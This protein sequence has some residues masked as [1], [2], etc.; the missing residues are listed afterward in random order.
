MKSLTA[1]CD[2]RVE[3]ITDC[4]RTK[5]DVPPGKTKASKRGFTLI[6]LLVV[7]AIIGILAAMLLPALNSARDKG[8]A[9]TCVNNLHQLGLMMMMYV[10]DTGTFPYCYGGTSPTTAGD[11]SNVWCDV[12][13]HG[14]VTNRMAFHCPKDPGTL[15]VSDSGPNDNRAV[16]YAY[17]W[18]GLSGQGQGLVTLAPTSAVRPEQVSHPSTTVLLVDCGIR[19][20][21]VPPIGYFYCRTEGDINN[22]VPYPRH[23]GFCNVCWVDGHVSAVKAPAGTYQSLYDAGAL[24]NTGLSGNQAS[25]DYWLPN[26]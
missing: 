7:I 20:T 15:G 23:Q 22:G 6:E 24:G 26:E 4:G 12:I 3:Q 8:K 9:A 25:F 18:I 19:P 16:S 17:N 10:N 11:I 1:N 13:N 5:Q 14:D 2:I 21:P